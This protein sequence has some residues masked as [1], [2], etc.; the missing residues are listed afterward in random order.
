MQQHKSERATV[1]FAR[2]F[3]LAGGGR[4]AARLGALRSRRGSASRPSYRPRARP[5]YPFLSLRRPQLL[6]LYLCYVCWWLHIIYQRTWLA[7]VWRDDDVICKQNTTDD[8][9]TTY[10]PTRSNKYSNDIKWPQLQ[11]TQTLQILQLHKLHY[12]HHSCAIHVASAA[13]G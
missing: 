8:R 4:L 13:V 7:I 6:P 9:R 2:Y 5:A 1:A 12:R 3:G 11:S 10:E